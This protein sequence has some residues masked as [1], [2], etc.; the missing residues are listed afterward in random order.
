[1][2][3]TVWRP[4]VEYKKRLARSISCTAREVPLPYAVIAVL[5]RADIP[6]QWEKSSRALGPAASPP[7]DV[8]A[9]A[10]PASEALDRILAPLR[11]EYEID[12]LG[13]FVTPAA[14]TNA[15]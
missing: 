15:E 1:V 6:Y 5:N 10:I 7:V 14:G 9:D 2:S 12:N 8:N 4:A 13:L 3:P 11:L